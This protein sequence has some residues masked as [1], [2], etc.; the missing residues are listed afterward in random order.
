MPSVF[1]LFLIKARIITTEMA[2]TINIVEATATAGSIRN[3]SCE[4]ILMGSVIRLVPTRNMAK[5]RSSKDIIK[6][7]IPAVIMPGLINGI[8][9]N[10]KVL[11]AL[12]PRFL[13]AISSEMS[14]R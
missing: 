5:I 1:P 2:E 6:Q 10:T 7:K 4:K 13:A 3:W 14:K 12:A 11:K 8:V 9:I